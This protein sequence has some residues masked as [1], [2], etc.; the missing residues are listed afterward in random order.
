MS[1]SD[2]VLRG[3]LTPKHIDIVE[4]MKIVKFSAYLPK[5][6]SDGSVAYCYSFP[7]DD[8]SLSFMSGSDSSADS[9]ADSGSD[10]GGGKNVLFKNSSFIC[11]ITEGELNIAG[12]TFKKGES[13]FVSTGGENVVLN[14]NYSLYA[15]AAK[16]EAART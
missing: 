10:S 11:L 6:L 15:A 8:F 9:G 4:L 16:E 7:C 12:V 14:G 1:S 13:F 2:N 3:G 5:V